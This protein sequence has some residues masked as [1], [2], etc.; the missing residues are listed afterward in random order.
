MNAWLPVWQAMPDGSDHER[1]AY[2]RRAGAHLDAADKRELN[3]MWK[4]LTTARRVRAE[5]A[6][7][8]PQ[9]VQRP[10]FG[11]APVENCPIPESK[12]RPA[13]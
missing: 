4:R 11:R 12:W 5:L 6:A 13:A 10:L 3:V 2:L 7:A 8:Q 1:M 9:Q